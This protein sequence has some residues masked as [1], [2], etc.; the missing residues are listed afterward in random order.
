MGVGR[1]T[2]NGQVVL[3]HVDQEQR[4]AIEPVTTHNLTEDSHAADRSRKLKTVILG[5]AK[6]TY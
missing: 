1:G 6:V 4:H 3:N 2:V 5:N